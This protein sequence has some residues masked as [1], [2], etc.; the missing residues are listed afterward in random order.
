M[1]LS[2][3]SRAAEWRAN[4][5]LV[6]TC[7][8]GLSLSTML[9]QTVGLV[10]EPLTHE[11]GWSRTQITYGP[12]L[13]AILSIFLYPPAGALIDRYG[14]RKIALLG[15]VLT[16]AGVAGISLAD[17]S[18]SQWLL[19]WGYYG[20]VSVLI[21]STIWML[22]IN[23][24]FKSGRSMA[25]SVALIGTTFSSIAV[26]PL[27]QWLTDDIGWRQAYVLVALIWG[28][29]T[30]VLTYFCLFDLHDKKAPSDSS[31]NSPQS[32]QKI[33]EIPGLSVAQALRCKPLWRIAIS[34]MIMVLLAGSLIVHKIPMLTEKGVSRAD[35]AL[36]AS[37]F[38]VA[39]VIGKLATGWLM[40]RFAAGRI[41]AIT[42]MASAVGL[43]LF[44]LPSSSPAPIVG[45]MLIVGYANGTKLQVA[46]YLTGAYAGLRNF[47]K[48]FGFISSIYTVGGALGPVL[49]GLMFDQTNS[50][51]AWIMLFVPGSLIAAAL[52][53]VPGVGTSD[54]GTKLDLNPVQSKAH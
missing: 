40:D 34:T 1:E 3:S 43:L 14:G 30:L 41:A 11:F 42:N 48:I 13:I 2:A 52:I 45:S 37:L 25:T 54:T 26:P 16:T 28:I 46:V 33:G 4:W 39:G 44:L 47:G 53:N 6:L 27:M 8:V 22:A 51:L 10:I 36:I 24:S 17:G 5:L 50:Y 31:D 21:K 29:P 19:L 20:V 38:G 18:V 12:S 49:A 35:A 7:F 32:F 15:I 9:A 23:S